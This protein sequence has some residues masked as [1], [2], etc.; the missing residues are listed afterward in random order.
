MNSETPHQNELVLSSPPKTCLQFWH[1]FEQ[2]T[3]TS[4]KVKNLV[5]ESEVQALIRS[6]NLVFESEV[7]AL[8]RSL[9][10]ILKVIPLR[11]IT[12][13]EARHG[14]RWLVQEEARRQIFVRQLASSIADA[15]T[16]TVHGWV[17]CIKARTLQY[18]LSAQ[19]GGLD[20]GEL[21]PCA[22]RI[23]KLLA[24]FHDLLRPFVRGSTLVLRII[25]YATAS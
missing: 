12:K 11:W 23:V 15:M 19:V 7:Q 6:L 8:I 4:H 9:Y 18:V 22:R 13:C 17:R 10:A 16:G 2:N 5:F 20:A 1:N 3:F 24:D 25:G 14:R 21:R